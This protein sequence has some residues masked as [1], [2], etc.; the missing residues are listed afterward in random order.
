VAGSNLNPALRRSHDP[1]PE[2]TLGPPTGHA[3]R[4]RLRAPETVKLPVDKKEEID[5]ASNVGCSRT[6]TYSASFR[7]RNN[8]DC[9]DLVIVPT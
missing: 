9:S 4:A 7:H 5:R 2:P 1:D 8:A 3:D 6:R